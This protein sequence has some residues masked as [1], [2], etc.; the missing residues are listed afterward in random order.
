MKWTALG[1]SAEIIHLRLGE[2]CCFCLSPMWL[3]WFDLGELCKRSDRSHK[4]H[5]APRSPGATEV[6]LLPERWQEGNKPL[7]RLLRFLDPRDRQQKMFSRFTSVISLHIV[8]VILTFASCNLHVKKIL[9]YECIFP[10]KE[11]KKN[12]KLHYFLALLWAIGHKIKHI[13]NSLVQNSTSI[14]ILKKTLPGLSSR[15]TINS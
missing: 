4:M 2:R 12:L 3:I 13:L 10:L 5:T 11:K 14:F 1:N 8:L 15:L 7:L 9:R 6:P